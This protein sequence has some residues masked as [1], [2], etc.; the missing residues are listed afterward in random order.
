MAPIDK[1]LEI[2]RERLYLPPE[3]EVSVRFPF[4]MIPGFSLH[5]AIP[6][7]FLIGPSGGLKTA[8]LSS[9]EKIPSVMLGGEYLSESAM[10]SGLQTGLKKKDRERVRTGK[11]SNPY[12]LASQLK[13]KILVINDWT[14][15]LNDKAMMN[16]VLNSLRVLY[17][18]RAS[19][20][21]GNVEGMTKYKVRFGLI[22][23][24]TPEID[25][26]RSGQQ[27]LGER[28]IGVRM[29]VDRTGKNVSRAVEN[30]D[31]GD[32]DWFEQIQ[33][34]LAAVMNLLPDRKSSDIQTP[35]EFLVKLQN[36]AQVAAWL[37]TGVS[38]EGR[39]SSWSSINYEPVEEQ[40][41]RIAR[42]LLMLGKGHTVL[43]A[44]LTQGPEEYALIKQ[45]AWGSVP[46]LPLRMA[47]FLRRNPDT[48]LAYLEQSFRW[49]YQTIKIVLDDL[50]VLGI[51]HSSRRG[52][53]RQYRLT[54]EFVEMAVT[55]E[56]FEG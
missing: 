44:R 21:Y 42:Q 20:K 16:R 54:D 13:G 2:Y 12:S 1:I 53:T 50:K 4:S 37:R 30:A 28:F 31:E 33:T 45:A 14:Q 41:T 51:V 38:R 3:N 10:F 52:E 19:V 47:F 40:G 48:A 27:V 6:W 23:G 39:G 15:L 17:D 8:I 34:R 55:S 22:A 25:R 7:G 56:F 29:A 26:V 5:S 18:G 36:I 11:Q 46:N 32:I 49:G 9:M 24:V 35:K 43:S